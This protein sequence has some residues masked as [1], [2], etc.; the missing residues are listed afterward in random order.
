MK[1]RSLITK[2]ALSGVA[3]AAT[4]A[5]LATSTYAWYTTNTSVE[6]NQISGATADAGEASI[7]ISNTG[8]DGSWR[9]KLTGEDEITFSST[10]LM[11]VTLSDGKWVDQ[12]GGEVSGSYV[13]FALYFKTAATTGNASVNLGIAGITVKNTTKEVVKADNLLNGSQYSVDVLKALALQIDSTT[14]PSTTGASNKHGYSLTPGNGCVSKDSTGTDYNES[15]IT[16]PS[17]KSAHDYANAVVD[18]S[19][20][21]TKSTTTNLAANTVF[22]VLPGDGKPVSA[23]F[24]IFLDGA[25]EDCFDACKGQDFMINL[26]FSVV[27]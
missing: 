23:T 6:A 5:T 19:V 16:D 13:E 24:R 11:P 12:I 10:K 20:T 3:L 18:G 9:Q 8:T 25:D 4:A 1:K 21:Q 14:S 2:L 17:Y 7:F 26:T 27:K 15:P 22:A